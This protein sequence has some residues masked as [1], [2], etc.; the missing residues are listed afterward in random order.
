MKLHDLWR[1]VGRSDVF[2]CQTKQGSY[3]PM[4][5]PLTSEDLEEHLAGFVS[6]GTYTI[7]PG[8]DLDGLENVVNFVVFD[9]DVFDKD[10]LST[11]I[12]AVEYLV[13]PLADP[14][15]Y[16]CLVLES[17][18]GKGYH[19]W[20]L[21]DGPIEAWRMRA[22][23][24]ER[25]WPQYLKNG[26]D[27]K[28]EVFPKQDTVREGGYG[29]LTKL[30][31]GVHAVTGV[32]SEI[33]G[34]KGWARLDSLRGMDTTCIPTFEGRGP[35]VYEA[36]TSDTPTG[37]LL[38]GGPVAKFL[39]GEVGQGER[40]SAFHAFFTWTAWNIHLPSN[41]AWEWWDELNEQLPDPERDEDSVR[42][43]MESAYH[44]PPVDAATRPAH[45]STAQAGGHSRQSIDERLAALRAERGNA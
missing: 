4:V 30:P 45:K 26:G 8:R 10:A 15:A 37:I 43:T 36:I 35:K 42:K 16:R 13:D 1:F 22:W 38:N 11:L 7:S 3:F 39:R 20:L 21:L 12:K 34:Q 18:G 31:C 40:N 5:R 32:R 25:F 44:R 27:P 6:I 17:S 28:L 41:L 2:A 29:N 33:L 14:D 9:L 19:I 23:L 24:D